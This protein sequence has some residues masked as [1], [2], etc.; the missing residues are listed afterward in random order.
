MPSTERFL[1]MIA[2][3]ITLAFTFLVAALIWIKLLSELNKRERGDSQSRPTTEEVN[4]GSIAKG[5][6]PVAVSIQTGFSSASS[7][8]VWW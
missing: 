5:I 6:E 2:L 8:T 3:C 1:K 4:S 7:L